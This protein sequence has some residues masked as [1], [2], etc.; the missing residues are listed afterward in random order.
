MSAEL[1]KGQGGQTAVSEEA[2][3]LPENPTLQQW[4][5]WFEARVEAR[6]RKYHE[7]FVALERSQYHPQGWNPT[8]DGPGECGPKH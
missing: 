5:D 6:A 8:F 7:K 3:L 2:I 1:T 4:K